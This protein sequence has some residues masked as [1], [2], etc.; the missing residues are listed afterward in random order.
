MPAWISGGDL[1]PLPRALV[2][3]V[4]ADLLIVASTVP[5]GCTQWDALLREGIAFVSS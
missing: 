1:H 2:V 3:D 5:C 4:D